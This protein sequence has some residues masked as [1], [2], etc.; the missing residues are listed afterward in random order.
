MG[1]FTEQDIGIFKVIMVIVIA[2]CVI[3]YIV[4]VIVPY[5]RERKYIK[6]ELGRCSH[7]EEH[8]WKRRLLR[9]NISIIPIFGPLIARAIRTHNKKD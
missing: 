3:G 1:Y 8:I 9:L 6:M 7:R 5:F 4:Q 2:I